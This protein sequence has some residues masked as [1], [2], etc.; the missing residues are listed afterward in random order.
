MRRPAPRHRPGARAPPRI[1]RRAA[2]RS[3]GGAHAAGSRRAPIRPSGAQPMSI[4]VTEDRG[5][6]PAR[7][8]EPAGEAQRDE[9]G[10]AARARRG[11]A[12][13]GRRRRRCTASCC[14]AKGPS[15]PPAWTSSSSPH[16]AGQAG[17][18]APVPQRVP[19]LREPLR[20]DGQAGRLPDPPHVRRR[21]AR[22]GAR[23]RPADRLRA[24][25]SSACPRSSSGSSPTS[26]APRACPRSSASAARRS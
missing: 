1:R 3:A 7:R 5:A 16:S 20:R 9:P 25:P 13:G 17:H 19:R 21:R 15:S 23:L 22:G 12:R 8:P 4:V 26:A 24:T 10:A 2:R 14:A 18:A 11:A 6:G